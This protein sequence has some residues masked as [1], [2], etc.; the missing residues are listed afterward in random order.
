M[1]RAFL[2]CALLVSSLFVAPPSG[3]GA[4]SLANPQPA[5]VPVGWSTPPASGRF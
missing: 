1:T 3:Q 5:T 2:V 4:R